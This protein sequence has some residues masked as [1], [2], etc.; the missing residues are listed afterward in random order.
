M[1]KFLDI[2]RNTTLYKNNKIIKKLFDT[3]TS[4][5][6]VRFFVIGITA[7]IIDFSLLSLFI[8]VFNIPAEEHLKQTVANV[9]SSGIAIVIN[10]FIQRNWAFESKNRNVGKEAGKFLGVHAFNIIVFQSLL[11]SVVNYFLPAWLTK[12]IV[13]FIQLASSFVL[14]KFFVFKKPDET[15]EALEET[16]AT[17]MV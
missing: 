13:T 14:Y 10:Y 7:F 16:V 15:D 5:Q 1:E 4:K 6:F 12:V 2:F 9:A 3:V 11:F 17:G 8:L